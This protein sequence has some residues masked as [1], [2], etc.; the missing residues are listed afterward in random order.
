MKTKPNILYIHSHDT[1]RYIQPYGYPVETPNLQKL[2]EQGVLFRQNFCTN[3]TCS[4]SRASLLTGTYPHENGMIGLAHRGFSLNDYGEHIVHTLRTKGYVS[5]LAGFQHILHS[6]KWDDEE[7]TR[8]IGYDQHLGER[9]RDERAAA[10]LENPPDQPFFLS[11]GFSETHREF[12]EIDEAPDDPRYVCPPPPLPDTPEIRQDMARFQ[13]SARIL[14]RRMGVVLD[15]LDRTGLAENTL[16]I[17]TT[18]HGIAFPRMK[19]NLHDSGT[20]VMLILRGPDGF[21]GGKVVDAMTSHLDIFPTLCDWIGIEPPARLRGKSLLPLI[22]GEQDVLHDQLV[23]EVNYHAAYEPMRAVRTRR[24]K[25]IKR[26]DGRTRPVLPNADDG[27]SKS[28]WLEHGWRD[29]TPPQEMLYDLV[30]DPNEANNLVGRPGYEDTLADMR[31]R[32]ARWM[33]ETRDPLR[34]GKIA[35]PAGAFV[36]DPDGLSPQEPPNL[37]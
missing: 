22:R 21:S 33:E 9:G 10:F 19:C 4:P 11:V 35:A 28:V 37:A 26:Y 12:P 1:G 34:E 7:T 2:A 6:G 18:D 13:A 15:A 5:V 24:W 14:D 3:P 23:F 36:N 31:T 29:R 30:F 8:A 20:G 27:E 25:Y 32:L 16:V 17:C